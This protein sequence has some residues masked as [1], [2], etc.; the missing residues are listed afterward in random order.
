[1]SQDNKLMLPECDTQSNINSAIKLIMAP[2][3]RECSHAFHTNNEASALDLTVNMPMSPVGSSLGNKRMLPGKQ[4]LKRQNSMMG[5]KGGNL[6]D[7]IETM[8]YNENSANLRSFRRVSPAKD[9][10][11]L[12]I[13]TPENLKSY[14]NS[15]IE[16]KSLEICS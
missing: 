2:A 9:N 4:D 12:S 11:A 6:W 13:R 15:V 8:L 10:L 1:M 3:K 14:A 16:P 5:D 7:H